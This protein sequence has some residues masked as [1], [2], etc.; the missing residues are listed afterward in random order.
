MHGSR[1]TAPAAVF[2]RTATRS[3]LCRRAGEYPHL[4]DEA[5]ADAT[6]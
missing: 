4:L 2:C 5:F 1:L 3:E 6:Y